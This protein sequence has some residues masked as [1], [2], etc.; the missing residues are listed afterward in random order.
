MQSLKSYDTYESQIKELNTIK[1]TVCLINIAIFVIDFYCNINYSALWILLC[2]DLVFFA[3][4]YVI[5]KSLKNPN[6]KL[7]IILAKVFSLVLQLLTSILCYII[8]N[9]LINIF[10]SYILKMF[11]QSGP[12]GPNGLSAFS[13]TDNSNKHDKSHKNLDTDGL[14][15]KIKEQYHNRRRIIKKYT[16]KCTELQH[17]LNTGKISEKT[18]YK[19]LN[20]RTEQMKWVRGQWISTDNLDFP[21]WIETTKDQL[22]NTK[23]NSK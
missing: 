15:P 13:V 11:Y 9:K 2:Y 23:Y 20:A 21:D 6:Y 14:P 12:G 5:Y 19:E 3:Y 7:Y 17:D 16:E 4:F 1:K 22:D 8:C 18:F 10:V